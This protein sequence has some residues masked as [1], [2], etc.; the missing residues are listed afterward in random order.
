MRIGAG[1]VSVRELRPEDHQPLIGILSD[2]QIMKWALDDRPFTRA[3]AEAFLHTKFATG[4]SETTAGFSGVP[5]GQRRVRTRP[6]RQAPDALRPGGRTAA[7]RSP[8]R[9]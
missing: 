7:E 2:E 9:V 4:R 5:P 3:E 1:P 8:P 6:P